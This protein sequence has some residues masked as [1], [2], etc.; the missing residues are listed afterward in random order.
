MW[1]DLEDRIKEDEQRDALLDSRFLTRGRTIALLVTARAIK[2]QAAATWAEFGE[3]TGG[4]KLG[5][6]TLDEELSVL[7]DVGSDNIVTK[8]SG[9]YDPG[10]WFPASDFTYTIDDSLSLRPAGSV[11]SMEARTSD[12]LDSNAVLYVASIVGIL[13]NPF[14]GTW[15]YFGAEAVAES[16]VPEFRGVGGALA[17][18]W[19]SEILTPPIPGVFDEPSKFLLSWSDLMVDPEGVCTLGTFT[20]TERAPRVSI[21]GDTDVSFR[22]ALGHKVV[23]YHGDFHDLRAPLKAQWSPAAPID[24]QS[25]SVPKERVVT[26]T[27]A[28]FTSA[29]RKTISVSVSDA[30]NLSAADEITVH[31]TVIPLEG[32]QQPF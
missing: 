25:E 23:S 16:F 2:L 27:R 12:D 22:E 3:K 8:L 29:G 20:P 26:G 7:H 28:L 24:E 19:P 10:W 9:T 15:V 1:I 18:Q 31:V 30:D 6:I 21:L 11:P 14:I 13:T 4:W 5:D 32:S 17:R